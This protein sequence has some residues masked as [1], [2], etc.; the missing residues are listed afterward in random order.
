MFPSVRIVK[1][2]L[3]VPRRLAAPAL[4]FLLATAAPAAAGS[5]RAFNALVLVNPNSP[6]S[7]ELGNH[8]AAAH[9]IPSHHV[10]PVDLPT[11][12]VVLSSNDFQSLL[13]APVRNHVA[14]NGLDGQI[15]FLVLCGA[16]PTRVRGPESVSASLFYGFKNAPSYWESS[17]NLPDYVSNA[18]YCAERAFRSAD[19]WNG[20]NGFVAFHLL[21][22]NLPAAKLVADRGA[23]AQS[24]FPPSAFY[25]HMLGSM[26]R[27]VRERRF[28]NAH[29]SFASLPGLPASCV[30]A[31]L[32]SNMTGK[33]NVAGYQD[34]Y[35]NVPGNVRTGNVWMAGAFA[36][37]LTSYGGRIQNF[38]N[39]SDQS[40]VL[41]WM[42]IGATASYGTVDEPC[43]FP[44]KF[45]DPLMAFFCARGFSLGDAYAMSVMAPYQ[46]LFAGDPLAA[47]FA[48]PPLLS[49]PSPSPFPLVSGSVPF[50]VS[51]HARSNGTPPAALDA[52]LDQRFLSSLAA[53]APS[54][55][56]VLSVVVANSSN[57][58]VVA[59]NASLFDAVSSLADAVN[60]DS[61][62]PVFA[63][64]RADRLELVGKSFSHLADNAPVAASVAQGVAPA[65]TLGVGLAATNLLPSAYR[66]R[67]QIWLFSHTSSGAN[68]NDSLACTVTLTNGVAVTNVL[69]ASQNES[70]VSILERL[71]AS[72]NANP[73]L[74]ADDG[75]YYDRLALGSGNV[76]RD[77]T[78]FAR[79]PGPDGAGIHVDYAVSP[80]STNSG[81]VTN[82]NFSST[83]DDNP[84][85]V[86]P[87]ASLLFHV[88][89]TNAVLDA[90]TI[91][92]TSALHDGVHVLD[93]VARDGSALAA[94]SRLSLPF[95]VANSSLV[96]S[97]S[98]PSGPA[99]PPPS[100]RFL[101]PGAIVTNSA[102][103]PPPANGTQL[104]CA[105]WTLLGNDPASGSSNLFETALTN[106]AS[107]EWLW[108]TNLWLDP[109]A[110]PDGSVAPSPS[111][112]PAASTASV[113]ALPNPYFQFAH[114]SG[115]ASGTNNPI[116]LPM[117]SPKTLAAHF[118]PILATNSTPQWWLAQFGWT[119]DFDSAALDDPDEDGFPTWREYL[120]DTDPSDPDSFLRPLSSSGTSTNLVF[121]VEPTSTAR[122]YHVD[123]ATNLADSPSWTSLTNAPGTGAPW[124]PEIQPPSPGPLFY[125]GRVTLPP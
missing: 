42:G 96:F 93:F 13:L 95:A 50:Q 69:F 105:G 34:G 49:A 115:D 100:L 21:A 85:D 8:Y 106:H 90:E 53:I 89:P 104:V 88:R 68:E 11:N 80:V 66:A 36:D 76:W 101:P 43:G 64:A 32:Y 116:L 10:C 75:V 84:D 56:N 83:L 62:S 52:Y 71:L 2:P 45:P 82:F 31:P 87:R 63:R 25:L 35:G 26:G 81:L 39:A 99:D 16:F 47:P 24:S 1:S 108:S 38:T 77:G 28:A 78:F 103:P 3:H 27:G 73:A 67:K 114:W 122:L 111:W 65:L 70:V 41:D 40:T 86:R 97:A 23:A 48:A 109:S 14:S 120:A 119:N 46:G 19:G 12:L 92:D 113:L 55:G 79:T 94:S 22:S 57:S 54:P 110:G 121:A 102:S 51:A 4:A 124:L 29:F 18:F 17:C 5:A 7:V 91:L 6:D 112:Q 37:H 33:T 59:S 44:E 61:N 123:S 9:G 15:D 117:D 20:T 98:S 107:L 60:A 125:R 74:M 30:L 72:I 118:A 58:A